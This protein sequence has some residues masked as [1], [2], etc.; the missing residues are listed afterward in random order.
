ML[1]AADIM[2]KNVVKIRGSATVAEAVQIKRPRRKRTGY[3]S[4]FAPEF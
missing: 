1:K 3:G 2:T 4:R